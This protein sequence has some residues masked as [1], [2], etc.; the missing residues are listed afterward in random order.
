MPRHQPPESTGIG[1]LGEGEEIWIVVRHGRVVSLYSTAARGHATTIFTANNLSAAHWRK[2][3]RMR[4]I[5]R[6]L[7]R[8]VRRECRKATG[9]VIMPS[10][11]FSR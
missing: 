10:S 6:V 4:S 1:A 2:A 7:R 9:S 3:S 5:W 11:R 8:M